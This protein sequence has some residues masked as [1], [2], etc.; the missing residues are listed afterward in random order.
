VL[1]ELAGSI[2]FAKV[3]LE[4]FTRQGPDCVKQIRDAHIEVF[5]DLKLHDIPETVE[6][7]VAGACSLGAKLLTIHT[8]GGPTMIERAVKRCAAENTGLNLVGVTVL[9][10]LDASDLAAVGVQSS[11]SDQALRLAR[12]AWDVGLR[13]FVCSPHEVGSLRTA[14][15]PDAILV[16]PGIRLAGSATHDQK[17]A[18]TPTRAILDGSNI[19]VVGRPIRD[20]ASP[21]DVAKLIVSEIDACL[22][23][24]KAGSQ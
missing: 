8:S 17:R 7:A 9:T 19:L 6:R 22:L 15:G 21:A 5:L 16:T 18:A 20:A 2:G 14:L 11:P 13:A 12:M 4:L 23:Q 1:F 24:R 10:S 3:G